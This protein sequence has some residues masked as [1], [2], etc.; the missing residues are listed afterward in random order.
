MR[1]IR[2]LSLEWLDALTAEVAASSEL[3]DLATHHTIGVTQVVTDGPE[4]TVVYHLQ[5]GDGAARFGAGAAFPEDVRMEQ[6]WETAIGVA[7]GTLERAGGVH[8]GAHPA[9]RQPAEAG[10]VA[11]PCSARSTPCS[12]P[13]ASAPSTSDGA[14]AVPELPEVQAHAERLTEQFRGAVLERFVPFNF[15]ALKTARAPARRGLRHA[16]AAASADGA[17][18]CCS[19]SG[20]S[21]SWCT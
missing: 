7:T 3:Q 5:V 4:G 15:T 11:S 12:A 1:V 2:Y 8:Q 19:T 18:T 10:G 21:T 16:A 6:T 17:S 20:R 9:H 14:A 13:S